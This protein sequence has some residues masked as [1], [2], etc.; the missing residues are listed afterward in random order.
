MINAQNKKITKAAGI[1]AFATLLSRISGFFR[2]VIIAKIFGTG[3]AA[4]AFFV[5]FRIPN[6]L[7]RL[8][9]EGVL[10]IA[11]IPVFMEYLHKKG[12]KDAFEFADAL[13]T[14]LFISLFLFTILGIV[15]SP[16]IV[17]I[18]AGGFRDD[19]EKFTLTVILTRIM[20]PFLLF[21]G[22]VAYFMGLLNSMDHFFA[23]A[24]GPVLLNVGMIFGAI[25]LAPLFYEPVIGL[26]LGVIIGGFSQF[27]FQIP[28]LRS[29]EI[30][31]KWR[32]DPFHAGILRVLTLML[33]SV[34]ALGVVQLNVFISTRLASHLPEGSVSY[35]YYADRFMELPL[36]IFAISV[37]TAILPTL[38]K[39][40]S[41]G[42]MDDLKETL[43]FSLRLVFFFTIPSMFL[44]ISLRVPILNILFQRGSFTYISTVKTA[45]ALLYYSLGLWAF[46]GIRLITPVFYSFQDT[47]TPVLIASV[48]VVVNLI[49]GLI[50]MF[51]LKHGGLALA[52][53]LAACCNFILLIIFLRRRIGNILDY[54]LLKSLAKITVASVCSASTAYFVSSFE[55]WIEGGITIQKAF[56]FVSSIF[57]AIVVFLLLTLIMKVEEV[58]FFWRIVSS[59]KKSLGNRRNAD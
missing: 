52:T 11:F 23:P 48:S 12:K 19:P 21:V 2:D 9:G 16:W 31:L 20:F 41:Q 29:K 49:M 22:M 50:L 26:S 38:S 42:K 15:F 4:D 30:R 54:G 36:G 14:L 35:L 6:I 40:A 53:S 58:K 51:P 10:T 59:A 17:Q 39:Q 56:I 1:I 34:F 44:L 46:S 7:R 43:S 25:L 13:Y 8:V 45:E 47:T 55:S 57:V 37:A 24:L 3:M 27:I 5:A 28:F 32:F 33:P 18:I